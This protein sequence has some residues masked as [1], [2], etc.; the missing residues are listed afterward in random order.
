MRGIAMN[1]TAEDAEDARDTASTLE[2]QY[3]RLLLL[4][5]LNNGQFSPRDALWADGWFSRWA[6]ALRLE[7]RESA[8]GA[9]ATKKGFVVD[10]DGTD[11]LRRAANAAP[12]NPLYLDPT[13]LELLFDKE[14]ESL[15]STE[16]PRESMTPAT[17]AGKIAL[18]SKLKTIYAPVHVQITRRGE[19][20]PVALAIQ[21]VTGLAN[22]I[23]I[24][25]EEARTHARVAPTPEPQ[26]DANTF[27][28]LGAATDFPASAA[29]DAVGSPSSPGASVSQRGAGNLAGE[30]SQRFRFPT[31]RAD[32][33]PQSHHSRLADRHS[34]ERE[35]SMDGIGGA[36]IPPA[37][38]QLCRDRRGA[39]RPRAERRQDG[40]EAFRPRCRQPARRRR[41]R[42]VR[43]ALPAAEQTP[44]RDADQDPA[45]SR[46]KFRR[47]AAKS[48][49]C[50][51]IRR[52]RFG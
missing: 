12:R 40:R 35:R 47:G 26:L 16:V 4:E 23:Q 42:Q 50:R 10:L 36:A 24:L 21:M 11:G 7:W 37:D 31:S 25:R 45:S 2:Q 15:R 33:R 46:A 27:S 38:G 9:R 28:P 29:E 52:T 32:R 48:R 13:P 44:T 30:G 39:H 8:N 41:S 18:L 6:K 20:E 14:L 22:I 34:R 51:R 43:G 19:R 17:R 1:S 5:V 3:I 49:C